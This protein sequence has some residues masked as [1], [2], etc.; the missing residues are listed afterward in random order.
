MMNR[1][2]TELVLGAFGAVFGLAGVVMG[3]LGYSQAN[4]SLVLARTSERR[5]LDAERTARRL[6]VNQLLAEAWDFLG[7]ETGTTFILNPNRDERRL[8]LARRLI[9]DQALVLEPENVK[10]HRYLGV[11][12]Y[13]KGDLEGASKELCR[14]IELDPTDCDSWWDL[15]RVQVE[16]D[17]AA[18]RA[19]CTPTLPNQATV[20]GTPSG[21]GE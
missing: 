14:A 12:L 15:D 5:A 3:L 21:G 2:K 17:G 16:A 9:Q 10:A 7:G 18:K 1:E 20:A 6:E 13:A 19:P 8:E 11:Y 4:R